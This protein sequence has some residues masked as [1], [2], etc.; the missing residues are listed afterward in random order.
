MITLMTIIVEDGFNLQNANL[1]E[2]QAHYKAVLAQA[3]AVNAA[4]DAITNEHNKPENPQSKIIYSNLLTILNDNHDTNL[5]EQQ[6][7]MLI[8]TVSYA[9]KVI[10]FGTP[11]DNYGSC[12][13]NKP[14]LV[15]ADAND[16]GAFIPEEELSKRNPKYYKKINPVQ[17]RVP[18]TAAEHQENVKQLGL[19]AIELESLG[20]GQLEKQ[21]LKNI[22]FY[23]FGL[24]VTALVLSGV[25]LTVGFGAPAAIATLLGVSTAAVNALAVGF[26]AGGFGSLAAGCASAGAAFTG[27]YAPGKGAANLVDRL[28]HVELECETGLKN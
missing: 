25:L 1:T 28:A 24:S 3:N 23:A 22:A 14:S 7:R 2:L 26:I 15:R 8:S 10:V 21:G 20:Q 18:Q 11:Q 16:E 9:M 12:N 13:V 17:K 19:C 27:F 6:L 4:L 5:N